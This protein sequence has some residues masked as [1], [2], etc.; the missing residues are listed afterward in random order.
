MLE[1]LE[2]NEIHTKFPDVEQMWMTRSSSLA[3][4]EGESLLEFENRVSKFEDS[5]KKSPGGRDGSGGRPCRHTAHDNLPFAGTGD[6]KPL[7][8]QG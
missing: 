5:S 2:F 6:E 7:E 3:Y 4:P 8:H 1:G